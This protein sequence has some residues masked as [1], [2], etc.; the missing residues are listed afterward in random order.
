MFVLIFL[1]PFYEESSKKYSK[2]PDKQDKSW[3]SWLQLEWLYQN[4]FTCNYTLSL[5]LLIISASLFLEK[6]SSIWM[7]VI[8]AVASTLFFPFTLSIIFKIIKKDEYDEFQIHRSRVGRRCFSYLAESM[9]NLNRMREAARYMKYSLEMLDQQCQENGFKAKSVRKTI[10]L[11][12]VLSSREASHSDKLRELASILANSHTIDEHIANLTPFLKNIEWFKDVEKV[13]HKRYQFS[14]RKIA[15]SSIVIAFFSGLI[16]FYQ[17]EIKMW[18]SNHIIPIFQS[19]EFLRWVLPGTIL[20]FLFLSLGRLVSKYRI[21]L[22]D[23]E[24]LVEYLD[25]K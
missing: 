9:A 24:T 5:L 4:Y 12:E 11:L 1:V 16:W 25:K 22:S 19:E 17:D 10:F 3:I 6:G 23:L 8:Q 7:P 2:I 21:E 15:T 13:S 18:L 20:F 14:V